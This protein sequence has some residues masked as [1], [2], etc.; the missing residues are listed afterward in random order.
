VPSGHGLVL[1][2]WVM[3][4]AGRPWAGEAGIPR[5]AGREGEELGAPGEGFCDVVPG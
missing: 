2:V 5:E 4:V 3:G 1:R